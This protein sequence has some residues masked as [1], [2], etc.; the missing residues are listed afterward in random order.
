VSIIDPLM[1]NRNA[2]RLKLLTYLSELRLKAEPFLRL[3]L[4]ENEH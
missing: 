3:F 2:E 4:L 1:L